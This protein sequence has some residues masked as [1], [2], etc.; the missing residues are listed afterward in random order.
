[1]NMPQINMFAARLAHFSLAQPFGAARFPGIGERHMENHG[2][3]LESE[4]H[5]IISN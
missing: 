1:M 3:T 4:Y 5:L 2:N